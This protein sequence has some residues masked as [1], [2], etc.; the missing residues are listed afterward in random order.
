MKMTWSRSCG[1]V[2]FQSHIKFEVFEYVGRIDFVITEYVFLV[3]SSTRR[4]N[5]WEI[6]NVKYIIT[7]NDIQGN[8]HDGSAN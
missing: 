6:N 4:V 3:F 1:Y 5:F 7:G 2:R 8:R